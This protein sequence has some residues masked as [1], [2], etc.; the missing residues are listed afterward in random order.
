[1]NWAML[2]QQ[3]I[4]YNYQRDITLLPVAVLADSEKFLKTMEGINRCYLLGPLVNITLAVVTGIF[5]TIPDTSE[6]LMAELSNGV[7]ASISF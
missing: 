2:W 6:Q 3:K 1:M 7:N 5:I 4:P